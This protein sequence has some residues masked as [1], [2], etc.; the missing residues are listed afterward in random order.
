[1]KRSQI[2]KEI[3]AAK[4]LFENIGFKLPPFAF[5]TP[6]I[7]AQKGNEINEI[8]DNMLGWDVT[9]YGC[10]KFYKTGLLLFTIRNGNTANKD[11]YSKTYA[12]KLM[13]SRENQIAPMHFHW[14]KREDIINRG[15][16]DLVMVL[17]QST[18][19]EKLSEK[20]FYASIDGVQT[21]ITPGKEVIL[22]PGESIFLKPFVYHMFYAKKGTGPVV[23]GEVSEVNDDENDNRFLEPIGRFPAI[24][25]D[26]APIH[27]LCTEYKKWKNTNS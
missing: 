26:E 4:K 24:E 1:M 25:E 12:E 22:K 14:N 13:I 15:G 2:N 11:K 19:D 17:Y 8:I 9:D 21:K 27:L 23:I 6:D 3:K 5:W 7:W 10:D 16:G 20:S 18:P